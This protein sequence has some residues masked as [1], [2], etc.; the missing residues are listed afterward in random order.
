MRV[1]KMEWQQIVAFYELVRCGSFTKAADK[2]YRTQSAISQQIKALEEELGCTLV[3]RIGKKSIKLTRAGELF[4]RFCKQVLSMYDAVVG[5][6]ENIKDNPQGRL[7]IAAPYTTLY[8]VLP[9]Y[10]RKYLS[11]Y[12]GIE[13]II[14][15]R[16]QSEVLQ[17]VNNGEVDFGIILESRVSQN[18]VVIPWHVVRFM[19]L[20]PIGHP[21]AGLKELNLSDIVQ[22]PLILPLRGH[23]HRKRLDQLFAREKVCCHVVMESSNVELSA[24]YVENGLGISF[25]TVIPHLLPFK[26]RKLEFIPLD[27]LFDPDRIAI[28]MRRG[29]ELPDYK[30][31]FLQ[32]L[33][34]DI[35]DIDLN[36][37]LADL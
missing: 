29:T 36:S 18:L 21:L 8:N 26:Y 27:W 24:L 20:T 23:P 3:E 11:Q 34:T 30:K 9:P 22:Y 16:T 19:L 32:N 31:A 12:P 37:Y 6:L 10:F 13:L 2:T 28:V 5:E 33:F 35:E 25:A 17:L 15:D 4:F 1:E 7:A 14:L